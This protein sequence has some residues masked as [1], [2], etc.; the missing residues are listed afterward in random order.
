MPVI[1]KNSV[2]TDN[3][4]YSGTTYKGNAGDKFSLQVTISEQI[5]V[6]TQNNPF[7]FDPVLKILT[8]P[9][10]SW[11]DEGL[12]PNDWLTIIRYNS[13]GAIVQ[14]CFTQVSSV[15]DTELNVTTWVEVLPNF[16]DIF[17]DISANDI[18]VVVA[19][20][21]ENGTSR[22]RSDLQLRFNH[23]LNDQQGNTASLIDGETTSVL[24]N[25]LQTVPVN[26]SVTG[27]TVGN[28]SGQFL[29]SSFIQYNG[30][31]DDGFNEY[32]LNF[33]FINS[34]IYDSSW[35][36]LGD[37][38][39]VYLDGLWSS[40]PG[41]V[42][43]R[44][45]FNIDQQSNTGWYN[46][47]NNLSVNNGST[48]TQVTNLNYNTTETEFLFVIALGSATVNDI[49][50]G[51]GYV[52][53][54]DSYYKNRP[55]NQ[56]NITVSLPTTNTLTQGTTYTSLPG[57]GTYSNS[58]W[59][60][61][62]V[63]TQTLGQSLIVNAK[64]K[65]GNLANFFSNRTD[66]DRLFRLWV[67]VGNIN[68]LIY[69][70]QLSFVQPVG[71]E[72][73]LTNNYGYL[74]HSQNVDT[75]IGSAYDFQA[76]TEDDIAYY[77]T[78][79][80]DKYFTDYQ[81]IN[82]RVEAFNSVTNDTFTLQQTNF[83]FNSVTY[84]SSTGKYLFNQVNTINTE[85]PTTSLK[86]DAKVFLTGVDDTTTYEVAV[87]YP[88]LLN[89]KYWLDLLNA[90]TDFAPTQNQNWE[91]YDNLTNWSIRT[92]VELVKENLGFV[93]SNTIVDKPYD[94]ED[95]IASDITLKLQSNNSIVTIM[96]EGEQLYIESTHTL[97]NGNWN[98]SRVWGMITVEPKESSPRFM[99]STIVPF[100]NNGSNPLTPVTGLLCDVSYPL[101]NV[102][103]L[104]C[105]FNTNII[106]TSNG[107]KITAKIKQGCDSI[108]E[109][110]KLTTSD[111]DKDTTD[112]KVKGTS[113]GIDI[114]N[115]YE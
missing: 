41:E 96:P 97:L 77:G 88:F 94:Y 24:Y 36:A 2:Y 30:L 4:G 75:V 33:N 101:P 61:E 7:T 78:F 108:V 28:Q 99:C 16:A 91:Q 98:Q 76:D 6:T 13:S 82:L 115:I 95:N 15:N 39:K 20:N 79:N 86:R 63:S 62:I 93:A 8:S 3:F 92:T 80:L 57:I 112:D 32:T 38:L 17:Y 25:N 18:M 22:R 19:T 71:G 114:N 72:L 45:E 81:S 23:S 12:R 64:W 44:Q 50:I 43:N 68:H 21:T 47:A 1:I 42:F 14:A 10:V 107:V 106:D 55:E 89:W 54:D 48:V 34:G 109:L 66:G 102:A 51:G 87:Y 31:D 5:R 56:R 40:Y 27:L 113:P 103:I 100:D 110:N 59:E 52:S 65:P 85:L 70:K 53:T 67:R 26:G 73:L 9:A 69:N 74:D 35:F 11:V 60:I 84:Q 46:E 111:I 37:C 83:N 29:E 49:G 90:S 105:K 58:S 104:K